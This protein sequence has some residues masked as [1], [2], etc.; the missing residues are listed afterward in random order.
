MTVGETV[1]YCKEIVR[2]TPRSEKRVL[3][4][5][6]WCVTTRICQRDAAHLVADCADWCLFEQN[7]V[8]RSAWRYCSR[9]ANV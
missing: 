8:S 1:S 5:T 9:A 4:R 3:L 7:M 6:N 2:S